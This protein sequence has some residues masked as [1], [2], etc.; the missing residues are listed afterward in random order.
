MESL[1]NRDHLNLGGEKIVDHSIMP[2]CQAACPLHMDVREYV[3]L[4]AQGRIM[5]ALQ[6]IRGGNPFPAICAYVCTHHCEDACRRGQIDKPVAIRSLKRFAV[7]FG[8]DRMIQAEA[9][10]AHREKIAIV[11]SGPAGLACAYYLRKMGYPV[12]VF[13]AHSELGGMLR[14]GIP[15]YR[16]PREV[17]DIEVQ[18]LIRMGVE[19]RTNTR[20]VSLDLLFDLGYKSIFIT[21][22][23]HQSLML[24]VEGEDSPGVIDGATFL[25][26]I[27]LGLKP[28]LGE[29]VGVV[30][31]GNVA[32]DV[33]RTA[34]RLGVKKVVILYR[35]TRAEMPAN[36]Q[37][38]DQAVEEGI[39]IV[40][41]VAPIKIKRAAGILNVVCT[42]MELGEADAGGRRRPVPIQ[43]SEFNNEYDTLITAIGQAPQMPGGFRVRVGKGSTIQVDPST[44]TTNR[45]GVFAGGDAVTGP[46]TVTE[47]LAA[48]R[49]A[50]SRIDDYLQ[51]RYP[52]PRKEAK[53]L[54]GD[55]LP[56]TVELIRKI[57]R[58]EPEILPA[59]ARAKDFKPV[60]MVYDWQAAV[61]EARRCLRCG[62]GA[63]ILF[64][65]KCASC[66]TCLRVCPY[67]VPQLDAG[68]TIQIS[69]DQCQACGI[70]VAECP[71]R[72]IVL[73]KP[74]DRRQVTDELEHVL[75][76]MAESKVKPL[77]VGFCCQYGLFGT[78]T[79]AS[80]WRGAKAGVWIVPVLCIAKVEAE[81]MLRAFEV[82]AEG[83]FIAGCGEQCARENTA[84]WVRQ[85]VKKVKKT[86]SEVGLRS[87]RIQVVI[88]DTLNE[89]TAKKLDEFTRGVAKLYLDSIIM[90]EVTK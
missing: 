68:G 66:L 38:V 88:P 14:V 9:E 45:V 52:L 37:E 25:R 72:A 2:P 77:V 43:G 16:L 12:T 63:E 5:E 39:E 18:R 21:I 40:Y 53:S 10:T 51:H 36:A 11:G 27:S 4:V 79:L 32:I 55:L 81:H 78:G 42:R 46:A 7:E 64:Q 62:Q 65:D 59:Q 73:R 30:G 44:L 82:G 17:L 87:E 35:R 33:A 70:C 47:A 19:I 57:G 50:A 74:Y 61:N 90:Q 1:V 31:G 15:Q 49:L 89:N 28:S 85:R 80:L 86:L 48:G 75:K 3:D 76:S 29:R 34:A 84:D 60:E 83:V 22:G 56:Q 20:V 69:V 71:A 8:G 13:E 23:A 24:G 41:L 26:E 58:L 67:H 54:I 6:I